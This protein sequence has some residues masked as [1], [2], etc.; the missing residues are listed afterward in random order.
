MIFRPIIQLYVGMEEIRNVEIQISNYKSNRSRNGKL[1]FWNQ[2]NA[3]KKALEYM[4]VF[5]HVESDKEADDIIAE[6]SL[7][8]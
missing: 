1:D 7:N 2:V 5:Q 8:V 3:F 6:L 4:G